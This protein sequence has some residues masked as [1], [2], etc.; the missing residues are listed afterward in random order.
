MS[1]TNKGLCIPANHNYIAK[2]VIQLGLKTVILYCTKCGD[3][4]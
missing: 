4:K 2:D 1:Y 3:K